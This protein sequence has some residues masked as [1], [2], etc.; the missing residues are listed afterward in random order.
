MR[1]R[2]TR[3][4]RLRPPA[5]PGR[6]AQ[7]AATSAARRAPPAPPVAVAPHACHTFGSVVTRNVTLRVRAP[8]PSPRAYLTT[9]TPPRAA[10]RRHARNGQ[11]QQARCAASRA[12]VVLRR[13]YYC[14]PLRCNAVF[15]PVAMSTPRHTRY[16]PRV[17]WRCKTRLPP[18]TC[19]P[20][21]ETAKRRHAQKQRHTYTASVTQ[22]RHVRQRLF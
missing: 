21:T 9:F 8:S 18:S 11:R 16:A 17:E 10:R 7:P 5:A 13:R 20:A 2:Y 4:L 3:V 6:R 1:S 15:T 19:A 22:Q 14:A 12:H